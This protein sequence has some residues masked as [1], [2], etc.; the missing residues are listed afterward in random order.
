MPDSHSLTVYEPIRL[1]QFLVQTWPDLGRKAVRECIQAGEILVN[2]HPARKAGQY[3]ASGDEVTVL[4]PPIIPVPAA[5]AAYIPAMDLNIAY[6]DAE[7]IIVDK[8]A[9]IPLH[10]TPRSLYPTLAQQLAAYVPD[11]ANIGGVEQAGMI[12]R[13]EAGISG[14]VIAAKT[15]SVYRTLRHSLK[16]QQIRLSYSVLVEGRLTGE[17]T[18]EQPIGNVKRTR[19]RLAVAREGRPARTHY[20]GQHHYKDQNRDYSLLLVRPETARRHQIQV[21]LSWYGFPV[22]GDRIYGSRHQ[23]LLQERVFIHLSVVEFL[24]PTSGDLIH[25]ESPLP[26]EL[27]S[28]LRYITRPKK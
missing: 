6:E 4:V 18:I 12:T 24:H 23:P 28:V 13:L 15:E 14:L 16:R 5:D 20:Q 2:A 22:V 7:L 26:A 10:P 1:D 17:E 27:Y 9:E 25:I 21:H 3:L 8:A 11:I 19:E